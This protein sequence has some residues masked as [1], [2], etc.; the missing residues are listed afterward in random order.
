MTLLQILKVTYRDVIK[1]SQDLGQLKMIAE[2]RTVPI[3][4]CSKGPLNKHPFNR[5]LSCLSLLFSLSLK[6]SGIAMQNISV[7]MGLTES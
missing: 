5:D 4:S 3:D 7:P 2:L 1:T 6:F